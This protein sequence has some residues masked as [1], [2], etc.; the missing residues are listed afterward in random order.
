MKI[1]KKY[2]IICGKEMI[3]RAKPTKGRLA[4]GVLGCRRRTCSKECSK[5]LTKEHK[6]FYHFNKRTKSRPD[7]EKSKIETFINK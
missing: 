2:C 6:K 5:I 3:V 4:K 1:T 7:D